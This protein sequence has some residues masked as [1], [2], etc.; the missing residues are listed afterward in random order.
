ENGVLLY[1]S[2]NNT[3][4]GNEILDNSYNFGVFGGSSPNFINSIDTSNTV[5]GKPIQYLTDV[6]NQV[7]DNQTNIGVLY[8]INSINMTVRNLNLTRNGHGVLFY[9]VTGSTIENV[10][11][12]NNSYG[13]YLQDSRGNIIE[14][15]YCFE[16]WV[17][18]C[19]QDSEYNVA[20]N[21]IAENCEKGLS[22]YKADNNNLRSNTVSNNLYGIRL[23]SSHFNEI[24]HNN[25]IENTNQA[26]LIT[27]HPN[28]WDNGC[29]GNYWSN[30]NGTDLNGD[31]IGDT[32]LP[33]EGLDHYPLANP[34]WNL[35]DVNH[36][37][38][39]NIY[40]VVRI[41]VA[42]G[43]T[44]S[45]TRWNPHCDI[46][47]PYGIIDMNDIEKAC[48]NYGKEWDNP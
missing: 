17:G 33:W 41:C 38:K 12:S 4:R 21:N 9:N 27:S 48:L 39:V 19:L 31:G 29:E 37:L 32:D 1:Y 46:A 18:I 25:L 44:P 24:F 5:N 36:D 45:D 47:E 40:D 6:E 42:Y 2:G 28:V 23:Y 30:Y 35:A 13:I 11:A 3:L 8:L 10:T 22:L 43:S 20:E 7:F 16:N 34:Y 15:N 26:D 14:N